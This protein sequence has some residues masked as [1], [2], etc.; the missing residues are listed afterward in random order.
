[1]DGITIPQVELPQAEAQNAEAPKAK[2][3]IGLIL[4][5][6]LAVVAVGAFAYAVVWAGGVDQV[7]S[8]VAPYLGLSTESPA[9]TKAPAAGAATGQQPSNSAAMA[10]VA[11]PA[12]AVSTMYEEQLT[13]QAGITAMV[14]DTV[15]NFEFSAPAA[16]E[17][18]V[19]VPLKATYR[20]GKTHTG[21][22][23]LIE[24]DGAWFF[25]GLDT[26]VTKEVPATTA[27]DKSVVDV[28]TKTQ[29]TPSSQEALAA[30]ADGTVTGMDVASVD[31]GDQTA[32]LNV[33]LHG[34]AYEGKRGRFVCVEKA[35]G[36]DSYWF[37]T[38]FS[39]Q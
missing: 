8:L 35:D 19:Q 9:S 23:S 16:A 39:W 27:V 18:G 30:F 28:I 5:V 31:R 17:N 1:M 2:R 36:V 25:A 38:G 20:D 15:K 11:L 37:V 3:R 14:E 13:S 34:G 33:V 32:G 6:V 29:A 7:R 24:I 10:A 21:T 26:G 4:A 12:W 22:I